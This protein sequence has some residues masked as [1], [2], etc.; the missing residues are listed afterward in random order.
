MHIKHFNHSTVL[1][2][3][4]ASCTFFCDELTDCSTYLG[5][6]YRRA[7]GWPCRMRVALFKRI[8]PMTRML[9]GWSRRSQMALTQEWISLLLLHHQQDTP[10]PL[11]SLRY[12]NWSRCVLWGCSDDDVQQFSHLTSSALVHN[13]N[14]NQVHTQR[15]TWN[16]CSS[17]RRAGA[18]RP[19]LKYRISP[20]VSLAYA[21]HHQAMLH[22]SVNVSALL[23]TQISRY[24]CT[25]PVMNTTHTFFVELE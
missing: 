10:W 6:C 12:G 13:T 9:A 5:R 24:V 22:H 1:C 3:H 21:V 14:Q 8:R 20:S 25:E 11:S 17:N 4:M 15:Q 16:F 18:C 2:I 19:M 7:C 23:F